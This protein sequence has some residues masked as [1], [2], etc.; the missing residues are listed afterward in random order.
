[1]PAKSRFTRLDAFAK[2]VEDARIRTTSGGIITLASLVVILYLVWGEWLDYRRVVV[3][4]EL[5][6]D[7]SRGERMEIHMN[8]TFP[9][10]P[11]ELLTLDVMDVS[12][13]QQVGVAHGVNKVRLSSP[14][15]GGRVL[16]VQALDLHSKEEVAKHLD[17]NYC[18]D[19]GGADPLPGSIKEGCCNTCDEVREAYAAKNWAFGKGSNIEQCER[20]GYAARIDAQRR[21]GCRLEGILRVNK[22][23][24]NFH[25]APGRSFTSGQ[26]HAHDLQN[27]LDLELPDNEKHTMTHH[28]HQ[29]RFGP[30]LPVEVSD[31]WQW[32]DHHHTNPLD[33]TSQETNDPAYN[34]VYFVKVVS[35]SYLPL[36]WDPLFSSAAHNAHD[37]IPLGSHGIA[38]GSGGSIET[39]QYSVTSH[40]R[41]LRGGDASDEGHKERLH[42]A[43]GIPGVFF[44]YDIS[45]M[46][47]INRE[48]RPKSFSGFLT[49]VCA[50]IGGTLTVAAAIDRGLYEGALRVKKLHSS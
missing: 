48:A 4:P 24:G 42:A 17:P 9:R 5:V 45:P 14:A 50:I 27:Y 7:K 1:M 15:E 8:I 16:D 30:Q 21:E 26:V 23:V 28:I 40:K 33:S 34:F 31:R 12:G 37:Q 41:S 32:T 44:N 18:G 11:C 10:L 46:K 36:G 22:V 29:L 20:E 6:V 49:G 13:E 47:V 25:I 2:T 3:L 35:T 19:C 38:Y 39:H 43:N